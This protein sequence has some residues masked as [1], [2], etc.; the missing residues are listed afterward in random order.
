VLYTK[1]SRENSHLVVPEIAQESAVE[2][3]SIRDDEK[4]WGIKSKI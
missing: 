4:R 1:E 3:I 2:I